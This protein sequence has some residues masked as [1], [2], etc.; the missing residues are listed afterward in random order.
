MFGLALASCV[1][2]AEPPHSSSSAVTRRT[3]FPADVDELTRELERT[4][5]DGYDSYNAYVDVLRGDARRAVDLL[6]RARRARS[7]NAH[8][9][10]LWTIGALAE[11]GSI[12]G[13]ED[14]LSRCA[15]P[16]VT[17]R[18]PRSIPG[19]CRHDGDLSH[20]CP[21]VPDPPPPSSE[22]VEANL[23]ALAAFDRV[24]AR[25]TSV[26]NAR[27]FFASASRSLG[28]G[29]D[30]AVRATAA[31]LYVARAFDPAAAREELRRGPL[32]DAPE[33][34][35]VR[36]IDPRDIPNPRSAR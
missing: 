18:A 9:V 35:D 29:C 22:E 4:S 13:L 20:D 36:L 33:L 31:G 12:P 7:P 28:P 26:D 11:H 15:P 34:A 2:P 5:A 19:R 32:A 10:V 27:R 16:I 21:N 24:V 14:E 17:S 1:A 3:G 8:V 6:E 30:S 23:V 25:R